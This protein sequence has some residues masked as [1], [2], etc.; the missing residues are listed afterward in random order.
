MGC[1]EMWQ[2]SEKAQPLQYRTP[3]DKSK[4]GSHKV[5]LQ[6]WV[7][8]LLRRLGELLLDTASSPPPARLQRTR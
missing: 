2:T 5:L 8:S 3:G 1:D 4:T 6:R 7:V